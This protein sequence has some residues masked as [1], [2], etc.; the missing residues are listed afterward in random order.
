MEEQQPTPGYPAW[1]QDPTTPMPAQLTPQAP[2]GGPSS[3]GQYE[4][5]YPPTVP[6]QPVYAQ[7]GPGQPYAQPELRPARMPKAEALAVTKKLKA[8]LIAGS[9]MALGVLAALAAGHVTG[10]SAQQSGAN[11]ATS[12]NTSGANQQNAPSNSDDGGYFNQAPASGVGNG[13]FGVSPNAPGQQ[14]FTSSST[15]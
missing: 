4:P 9:V 12:P 10:V 6:A 14:P 13:G 11:N 1:P 2:Q 15:S 7:W 8:A 3:G 5:Y